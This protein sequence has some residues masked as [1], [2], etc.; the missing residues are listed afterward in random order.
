MSGASNWFSS[1]ASKA[2]N[3][4]NQIDESAASALQQGNEDGIDEKSEG[5]KRD[6]NPGLISSQQSHKSG[7]M[8]NQNQV[9]QNVPP[10]VSAQKKGPG[11][12]RRKLSTS[13]ADGFVDWQLQGTTR[14]EYSVQSENELRPSRPS[15]VSSVKSNRSEGG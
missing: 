3:V 2:E 5:M 8:K 6:S 4:L 1:L 15:S 9:F 14:K 13:S 7:F 12:D 11:K 10:Y